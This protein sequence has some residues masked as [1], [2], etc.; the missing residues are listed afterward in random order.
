MAQ[1]TL[2]YVLTQNTDTYD[3]LDNPKNLELLLKQTI[4]NDSPSGRS[5]I[6][7]AGIGLSGKVLLGVC[8][9]LPG[10]LPHKSINA[11]QFLPAN[12]ALNSETQLTHLAITPEGDT[13]DASCNHPK[14]CPRVRLF[15]LK[16]EKEKR[17]EGKRKEERGR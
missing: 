8:V 16:R 15:S 13:F 4:R 3:V 14:P 11:E 12:L 17:R 2:R 1:P 9:E 10:F 6:V 5:P 7:A